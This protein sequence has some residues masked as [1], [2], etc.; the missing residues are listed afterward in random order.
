MN[1]RRLLHWASRYLF[2]SAI[3]WS[4]ML[5]CGCTTAWTG[6]A[7]NI[8][9]VLVPAVHAILGLIAALGAKIP[10]TAAQAIND[11][12]KQAQAALQQIK[13]LIAQYEN[14]EATAKPGLLVEIQTAAETVVNNLGQILPTLHIT[15]PV[16][17]RKVTDVAN[18][19]LVELQALVNV[20]PALQGKL[21]L[22][23]IKDMPL[24]AGHFVHK[25]NNT[26]VEPTGNP[27]LDEITQDYTLGAPGEDAT[28]VPGAKAKKGKKNNV[29]SNAKGSGVDKDNPEADGDDEG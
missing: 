27:E 6:E 25:F 17:Q 8:I 21:H 18:A 4:L 1:Y 29:V 5:L 3:L 24:D 26:M 16:T 11:W 12:G 15:D 9:N 2:L 14:A 13:D 10:D 7:S 19:I 28:P 22:R 20:I 23:D